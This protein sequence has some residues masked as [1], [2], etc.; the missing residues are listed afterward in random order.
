MPFYE[1]EKQRNGR[2]IFE[3]IRASVACFDEVHHQTRRKQNNPVDCFVAES[4]CHEVSAG[5]DTEWF[6]RFPL[7]N[8]KSTHYSVYFLVVHHQGLEPGTP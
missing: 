6:Y 3:K 4:P 7:Q 1:E 2:L 8:K 5:R